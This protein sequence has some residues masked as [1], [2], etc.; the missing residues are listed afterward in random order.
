MVAKPSRSTFFRPA[1]KRGKG[2]VATALF[3]S[4]LFAWSYVLLNE[5]GS[6]M[7]RTIHSIFQQG[8]QGSDLPCDAGQH[9]QL[10]K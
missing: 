5:P 4:A 1:M 8:T 2:W 6:T 9:L 10:S 7:G 3:W